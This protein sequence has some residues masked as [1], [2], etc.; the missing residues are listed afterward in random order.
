MATPPPVNTHVSA[1]P[2]FTQFT[3]SGDGVNGGSYPP[4]E[5]PMQA[6]RRGYSGTVVVHI[7][8]DTAG[9]VTSAEI[10]KSSGYTLLD[11]AAVEVVK[12]RWRFPPGP[13]RHFEWPCTFQPLGR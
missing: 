11:E 3:P 10:F 4:P 8:V 7:F 1:P 9:T 13:V 5:Y 6:Q 12:R 2:Q